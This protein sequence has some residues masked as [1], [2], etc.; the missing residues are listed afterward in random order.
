M[1]TSTA[2]IKHTG[3]GDPIVDQVNQIQAAWMNLVR[4]VDSM[5]AANP[6]DLMLGQL[7]QAI[8]QLGTAIPALQQAVQQ[9]C[10]PPSIRLPTVPV[11]PPAEVVVAPASTQ[12]TA[13]VS[14]AVA[15]FAGVGG[16]LAGGLAGWIGRGATLRR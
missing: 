11:T 12:P 10:P 9:G 4:I 5:A 3:L 2:I 15:A 13:G 1:S 7:E 16:F 6:N 14:P 8:S